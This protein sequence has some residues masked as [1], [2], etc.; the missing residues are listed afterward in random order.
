MQLSQYQRHYATK[1][2]IKL[3]RQENDHAEKWLFLAAAHVAGQTIL[4][5]HVATHW[6]MLSL[7]WQEKRWG[8]A[9][10]QWV[11]LILVPI[12]H[13]LGRLPS[14]NPGTANVNAF[15]AFPVPNGLRI[16]IEQALINS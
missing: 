3:A 5:L 15:K 4:P 10:G 14:G 7:A 11:R 9:W 2:L 1:H 16:R 8:E 6:A 13:V 12:G